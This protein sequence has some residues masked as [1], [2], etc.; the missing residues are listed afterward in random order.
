VQKWL[1]I[2]GFHGAYATAAS[3]SAV[4]VACVTRLSTSRPW[5]SPSA[6]ALETRAGPLDPSPCRPAGPRDRWWKHGAL[7]RRSPRQST[8]E[9]P[10]T[11]GGGTGGTGSVRVRLFC[12]A[13]ASPKGPSSVKCSSDPPLGDLPGHGAVYDPAGGGVAPRLFLPAAGDVAAE[14]ALRGMK[15]R[16]GGMSSP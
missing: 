5:G 12:L 11:S 8:L 7:V 4:P 6:R 2:H 16:S 13:P 14:A 9:F 15:P 1:C 3:R 10:G